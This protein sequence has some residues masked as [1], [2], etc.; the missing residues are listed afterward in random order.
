MVPTICPAF[1]KAFDVSHPSEIVALRKVYETIYR[2]PNRGSNPNLRICFVAFAHNLLGQISMA[3][4][5]GTFDQEEDH[6]S[7]RWA[8][9]V[10]AGIHAIPFETR[11]A[12]KIRFRRFHGRTCVTA[13]NTGR[14]GLEVVISLF[15]VHEQRID[16]HVPFTFRIRPARHCM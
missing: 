10:G 16:I 12:V 2:T 14:V 15:G 7:S 4:L 9:F 6:D 5:I 13:V 3:Y 1:G 11:A 8:E